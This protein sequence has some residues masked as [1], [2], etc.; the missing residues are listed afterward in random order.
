MGAWLLTGLQETLQVR[1]PSACQDTLLRLETAAREGAWVAVAATYELGHAL[2]PCL[3]RLL[4]TDDRVLL[5][6]WI[7]EQGEWLDHAACEAWLEA[8]AES[9]TGGIG[10]LR[11]GIS[12]ADYL[13]RIA[14]IRRYIA[15]GDCYQVNFTFPLEGQLFGSRP[16]LYQALRAAQPVRFGTY[17]EHADGCILSRSPELF[18]ER[19]GTT[20]RSQPMKGTAARQ[21]D[22][23]LLAASAK[24]RAENV[25]IVDLIRNDMG[26]LAPAGGVRVEDLFHIEPYPTVWQM[27]SRVIAEPVNASLPEI[28]QALFP[29]GSITGAP[30]IR[31]MQRIHELE[32]VPRGVYCGALG[33]IRPGGDFR[34]SVPIRTL[35]ADTRGNAS[36]HVGS[37]VVYDSEGPAEWAECHLKARF[38]TRL[39]KGLRLIETLR[40]EPAEG[41]PFPFLG[42]HLERMRDS[43]RWLDFPFDESAFRAR[44]AAVTGGSALRVRITLG[45]A[46]DF[47][48]EQ[49]SLTRGAPGP[50][51]SIVL[52][53]ERV[54][55]RDPLL[56]HKTTARALYDRELARVM[57]DGHFDVLFLN[58]NDELAEGARSNLFIVRNGT[59]LTPLES[60]GL[61]N[62]VLRRRLIRAGQAQECSLTVDDLRKAEA[63]YMGNGLR[64]LV[65]VRLADDL[66]C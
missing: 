52:S 2:E 14:R 17:I 51:P 16:A 36:L 45:Q 27:T 44:L 42:E 31:A 4:P 55:S 11:A 46:G 47:T 3:H 64:G 60:A 33:W 59:L 40:Y 41:A 29:C 57:A 63:I 37:G 66:P 18:I 54:D 20:L 25:M 49:F 43:A 8:R 28:F 23:A 15:D 7:F 61:L 56:R 34:F 62:G 65:Q 32:S 58:E 12:E 35:L 26:R 24:D 6:G 48:L 22:P 5:S 21:S 19:S 50:S 13:N 39:P 53:P 9:A 1:N 30:K 38:L 10:G